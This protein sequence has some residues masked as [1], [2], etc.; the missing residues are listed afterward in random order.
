M[1]EIHAL[2]A[3]APQTI[4]LSIKKVSYQ[5]M[6]FQDILYS[7]TT[8]AKVRIVITYL[9]QRSLIRLLNQ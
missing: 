4:S 3:D 7:K 2:G 1:K 8:R 6:C 9:V 5:I